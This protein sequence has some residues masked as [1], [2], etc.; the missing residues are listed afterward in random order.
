MEDLFRKLLIVIIFQIVFS[1]AFP[2]KALDS[3]GQ[4]LILNEAERNVG[5]LLYIEKPKPLFPLMDVVRSESKG[6]KFSDTFQ[7][8]LDVD[9]GQLIKV[10]TY[11]ANYSFSGNCS[12]LSEN[13]LRCNEDEVLNLSLY[14]QE[15][16]AVIISS[17]NGYINAQ[18]KTLGTRASLSNTT[19][20]DVVIV[21]IDTGI[22]FCHKAFLNYNGY[23]R[24]LFYY[25]VISKEEFDSEIINTKIANGDC[26]YDLFAH[27]TRVANVAAGY[28]PDSEYNG[29]ATESDLIIVNV[30]DPSLGYIRDTDVIEALDYVKSKCELLKKHCVLNLSLGA[31]YGPQDGTS[32][33]ERKIDEVSGP[34]FI[35]VASAGNWGDVPLH[36]VVRNQRH[37][38]VDLKINTPWPIDVWYGKAGKYRVSFCS[39]SSCVRADPDTTA[40]GY[41]GCN[42]NI[43]NVSSV[44]LNGDGNA[45]II[46]D[47]IGNFYIE[48]E[49]VGGFPTEVHL[50]GGYD[51]VEFLNYV[52][53]DT[54]GGVLGTIA[55]PASGKSVI[56]V[57][58]FT[59]KVLH[60]PD[61]LA[62]FGKV[63]AFS[64]RGP[65][66]DGRIKPDLVAPGKW[67][68]TATGAG[69]YISVEGTSFSAPV[70]T[71]LV[72]LYLQAHPDATP[73]E[74][75]E[76]LASNAILDDL[77]F[78]QRPNNT[79]GY[80]K[81]V[82]GGTFSVASGGGS[83]GCMTSGGST[84]LVVILFLMVKLIFGC[85]NV[86]SSKKLSPKLKQMLEEGSLPKQVLV[87]TK[88][89]E[90]RVIELNGVKLKDLL[91]DEEIIYIDA[92]KKLKPFI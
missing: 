57:G 84:F 76:W 71:G 13:S 6:L 63:T 80:G 40:S 8:S 72:A 88:D 48:L 50:Y 65:T 5:N 51:G 1:F 11:N 45:Y 10:Y 69:S 42:V 86:E 29:I 27:G 91:H 56:A 62:T 60:Y 35:V 20:K 89:G 43:A 78:Q 28:N 47:C 82:W 23:T 46:H 79:Y 26:N 17:S 77:N 7:I 49:L 24:I 3:K 87:Y 68:Y 44:P 67:I 34:G 31:L 14:P 16:G 36:A 54:Y 92:S 73:E 53:R 64:S 9:A 15:Q 18:L 85:A 19:G 4:I 66:R 38:R 52:E 33:L 81:A 90:V 83:G 55:T 59:S 39:S 58:A 70:V 41:V 25:D 37:A 61:D 2:L 75:K 12:L 32:F 74:V 30:A 21:I 22:N